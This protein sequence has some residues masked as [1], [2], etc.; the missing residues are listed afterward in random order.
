MTP[1]CFIPSYL[2]GVMFPLDAESCDG[3]EG[4]FFKE[5]SLEELLLPLRGTILLGTGEVNDL[6]S[7]GSI[8]ADLPPPVSR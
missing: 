4:H 8:G 6:D 7:T 5:L 1:I 2:P 3:T